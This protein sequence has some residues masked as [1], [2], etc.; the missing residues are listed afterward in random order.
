MGMA[1][2]AEEAQLFNLK[3]CCAGL[4]TPAQPA[5]PVLLG[6]RRLFPT[7]SYCP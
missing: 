3:F 7:T 6:K 4:Q 1:E 2:V 5:A